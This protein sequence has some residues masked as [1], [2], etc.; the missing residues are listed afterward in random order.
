MKL[1]TSPEKIRFASKKSFSGLRTA[2]AWM[3]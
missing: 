3:S 2:I 1:M